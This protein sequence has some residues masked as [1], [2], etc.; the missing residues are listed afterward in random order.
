MT[1]KLNPMLKPDNRVKLLLS[2]MENI[3]T[4]Q[5]K[6]IKQA[7]QNIKDVEKFQKGVEQ[8][9]KKSVT[10]YRRIFLPLQEQIKKQTAEHKKLFVMDEAMK[11]M[12]DDAV[13]VSQE[14]EGYTTVA[15]QQ[16]QEE[17]SRI[18]KRYDVKVSTQ[19]K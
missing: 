11:K 8:Q 14:I 18:M 19:K 5:Q 6:T 3:D 16:L 13:E 12:I 1:K 2:G 10:E 4:L 15:S 9:F 7:R 17:V